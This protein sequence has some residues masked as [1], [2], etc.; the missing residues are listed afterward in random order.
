MY[1]GYAKR[2]SLTIRFSLPLAFSPVYKYKV[3]I[4]ILGVTCSTATV[5][6]LVAAI[7]THREQ[8]GLNLM[9]NNTNP[10][11]DH[12]PDPDHRVFKR[13]QT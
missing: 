4:R 13:L 5:P 12:N 11:N 8:P 10:H 7:G 6:H 9:K 2:H 1:L 3:L